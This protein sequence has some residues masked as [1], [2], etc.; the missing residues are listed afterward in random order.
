M[1]NYIT[2]TYIALTMLG[3]VACTSNPATLG[4]KF[5]NSVG[6]IPVKVNRPSI[7]GW[8]VW[9]P[10]IQH[11]ERSLTKYWDLPEA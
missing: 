4:A 1:I 3:V 10:V 8:I 11:K 5:W 7:G 6:S 9:P 2:F